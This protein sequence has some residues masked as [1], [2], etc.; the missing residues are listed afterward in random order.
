M[1]VLFRD[2]DLAPLRRAV[3]PRG[4]TDSVLGVASSCSTSVAVRC[5]T[6]ASETAGK[7]ASVICADVGVVLSPGNGYVREAVVDQQ[8]AHLGVHVD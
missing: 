7:L 2:Y 6:F 1:R 3:P 5:G 4:L 8:L